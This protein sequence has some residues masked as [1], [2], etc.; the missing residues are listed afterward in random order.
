MY[1][2]YFLTNFFLFLS[3][4]YS[5]GQLVTMAGLDQTT[6]PFANGSSDY[7]SSNGNNGVAAGKNSH[8]GSGDGYNSNNNNN[9]SS[10]GLEGDGQNTTYA[11]MPLA[12]SAFVTGRQ[13][14][15]AAT[16][17]GA[18]SEPSGAVSLVAASYTEG[19]PLIIGPQPDGRSGSSTV[20]RGKTYDA[21]SGNTVR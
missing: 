10:N 6:M 13:H 14:Q 2:D 15:R 18:G 11:N 3:R 21:E 8:H 4:V 20:G 16:V 9:T 1:L 19:D 7:I 17:G 12:S 5:L